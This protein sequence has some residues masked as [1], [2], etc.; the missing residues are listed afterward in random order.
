MLGGLLVDKVFEP[1]MGAQPA[2]SPLVSI[3]GDTKGSGAAMLFAIIGVAG[4]LVCLIFNLILQKYKW[5]DS[6]VL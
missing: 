6:T 2:G 3:F 4:V 1:L 5:S